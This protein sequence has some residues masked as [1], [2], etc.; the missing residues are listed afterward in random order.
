MLILTIATSKKRRNEARF[1]Q[2]D[3]IG[4]LKTFARITQSNI[5][6]R[7]SLSIKHCDQHQEQHDSN[8][9]LSSPFRNGKVKEKNDALSLLRSM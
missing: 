1:E 2:F 6:L 3:G 5:G 9:H 8:C 7:E 4:R